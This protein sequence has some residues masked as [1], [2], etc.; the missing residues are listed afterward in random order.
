MRA[1]CTLCLYEDTKQ[2][3]CKQTNKKPVCDPC[4]LRAVRFQKTIHDKDEGNMEASNVHVDQNVPNNQRPIPPRSV[5]KYEFYLP[6]FKNNN[7]F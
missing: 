1:Y 6:N 5:V 3:D 2:G 7:F 4:N